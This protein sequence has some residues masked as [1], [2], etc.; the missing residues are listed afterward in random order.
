MH[1]HRVREIADQ[2]GLSPATVDRVLNRRAGVRKSTAAQVLRAIAELDRQRD[3]VELGGRTFRLDLVMHA[4]ARSSS[5]VR[6]AL[7]RATQP[8]AGGDPQPL[9]SSGGRLAG[10]ARSDPRHDR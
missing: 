9:P 10:R 5:A 1:R 2:S 8:A 3:Q 6:A 4:P 7:E